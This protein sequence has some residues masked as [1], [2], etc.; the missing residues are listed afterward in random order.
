MLLGLKKRGCIE[1]AESTGVSAQ[2]NAVCF[3][4]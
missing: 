3:C 1:D 4:I 2:V